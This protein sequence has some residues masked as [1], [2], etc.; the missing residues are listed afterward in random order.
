MDQKRRPDAD[1]PVTRYA[2]NHDEMMKLRNQVVVDMVAES[3]SAQPSLQDV[4]I[5]SLE[6]ASLP[7]A[8]LNTN[9]AA[10]ILDAAELRSWAGWAP[11]G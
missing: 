5:A 11:G 1:F 8:S 9:A 3:Q 6:N 7:N 4:T 2:L 10:E